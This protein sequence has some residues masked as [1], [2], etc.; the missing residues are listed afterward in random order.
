MSRGR[1]QSSPHAPEKGSE[2]KTGEVNVRKRKSANQKTKNGG[3]ES[4]LLVKLILII[5]IINQSYN[6][7]YR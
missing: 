3:G 6:H 2:E 5:L 1:I 7:E 4:G